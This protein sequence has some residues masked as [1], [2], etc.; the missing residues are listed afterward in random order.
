MFLRKI[1]KTEEE[2]IQDAPETFK[3]SQMPKIY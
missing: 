1:R 2:K 3:K